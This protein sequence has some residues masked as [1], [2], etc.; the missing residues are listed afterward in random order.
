MLEAPN[1]SARQF[2]F[3]E[4]IGTEISKAHLPPSTFSKT[5]TNG[6]FNNVQVLVLRS[7]AKL[8][9]RILL[10]YVFICE[11]TTKFLH[12]ELPKMMGGFFLA[13]T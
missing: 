13:K 7:D 8:L 12:N 1:P 10:T 6:A 9:L 5:E 3:L 4:L 2:P 11:K